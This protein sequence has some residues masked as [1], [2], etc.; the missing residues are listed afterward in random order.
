MKID[1]ETYKLESKNF[2]EKISLK[3]QIVIGNSLRKDH[4]Y[5]KHLQIKEIGNSKEWNMFTISREGI[6][7]QHFDPKYYS[8]FIGI[9]KIDKQI[10]SIIL[11]NIGGLIKIS[12]YGYVNLL[13]EK[14][15]NPKQLE[16]KEWMNFNY[17]EIYKT[18]QIN[19]LI[20]LIQ[21][22]IKEFKI[23]PLFIEFPF[24]HKDIIYNGGIVFKSNYEEN[25]VDLNPFLDIYK[26]QNKLNK[27]LLVL[28]NNTSS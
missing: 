6:I 19:A 17:W 10:I 28:E 8:D 12:N 24:Y 9:K 2:Y 14:Y 21:N 1:K 20:Y 4:N 16:E 5:L 26:L 11:E 18:K 22:L 13:N 25:S 3:T 27:K 15:D 7:Y 23:S